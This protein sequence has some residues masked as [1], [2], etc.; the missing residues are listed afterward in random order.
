M[1]RLEEIKHRFAGADIRFSMSR[2]DFDW[3]IAGVERLQKKVQLEAEMDSLTQEQEE[4]RYITHE[5][6]IDAGEPNLE[7]EKF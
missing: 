2:M 6:A 1:D 5:M 7:G 4:E 3:L